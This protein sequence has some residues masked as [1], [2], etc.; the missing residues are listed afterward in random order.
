MQWEWHPLSD[1]SGSAETFVGLAVGVVTIV[2]AF[3]AWAQGDKEG[4]RANKD[5]NNN[6]VSS[7][8]ANQS[9][10]N[11]ILRGLEDIVE[12]LD[13]L[14]DVTMDKHN[15]ELSKHISEDFRRQTKEL[16]NQIKDKVDENGQG[17]GAGSR[18]AGR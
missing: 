14:I 13:R 18:D 4:Q 8:F 2:G 9:V 7:G 11:T 12:R 1:A 6:V 10:Q 3:F 16:L 17:G 15:E 5:N